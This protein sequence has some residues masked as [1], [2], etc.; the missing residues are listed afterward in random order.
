[1]AHEYGGGGPGYDGAGLSNVV[2]IFRPD[3]I[4]KLDLSL[5]SQLTFSMWLID[6]NAASLEKEFGLV[7]T[8]S[9]CDLLVANDKVG[10]H[11]DLL[12]L[13]NKA[14]MKVGLKSVSKP[15]LVSQELYEPCG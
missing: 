7:P 6:G 13:S 11:L 1:M 15:S 12:L 2:E 3:I 4:E 5:L 10:T 9:R 8:D 14:I